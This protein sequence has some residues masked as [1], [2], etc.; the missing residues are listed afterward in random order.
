MSAAQ[1]SGA[2]GPNGWLDQQGFYLYRRDRLI[3]AGDWLGL[4]G[5]RRD[6][7]HNLA[8]I[9]VDVPAE[10]DDAWRIDV[11]KSTAVPP[12]AI[13][14]H[15]LRIAG[16]A[17]RAAAQ[18]IS[19]RG[20]VAA[21]T[22]AADFVYAWQVHRR[23]GR[24]TCRINRDH[25]L[26]RQVL[27]AG[28]DGAGDARAL[29]SL[30]EETVPVATLRIM[31]ETDTVDDPEPFEEATDAQTLD[32]AERIFSAL[33]SQGHSPPE[34]RRRLGLIPPFDQLDGFWRR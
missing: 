16:A 29:I 24:I 19:H 13:R 3:L 32:V 1:A 28:A 21:R 26:V 25:P 9:A 5:L 7:K 12:V 23:D 22:H 15:L 34:A 8:R 11:R 17:R 4:R 33:L 10:L 27:R 6:E 14:A 2:A 30:L 20:Q 31:H 18:V